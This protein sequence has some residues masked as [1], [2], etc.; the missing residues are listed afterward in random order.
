[1]NISPSN[2]IYILLLLGEYHQNCLAVLAASGINKLIRHT[3][4][5]DFSYM[6]FVLDAALCGR[7]RAK[8]IAS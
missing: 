5:S 3:A 8:E 7:M 1:M 4:G 6:F 2:I